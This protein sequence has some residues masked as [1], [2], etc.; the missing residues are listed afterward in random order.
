MAGRKGLGWTFLPEVL[1]FPALSLPGLIALSCCVKWGGARKVF[2]FLNFWQRVTV[3][4]SVLELRYFRAKNV[5]PAYQIKRH[6]PSFHS[7]YMLTTLLHKFFIPKSSSLYLT[8]FTMGK[9]TAV[10]SGPSGSRLLC[11]LFIFWMDN[12]CM[13]REEKET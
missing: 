3:P 8:V 7:F 1:S 2:F 12:L 9:D 5:V 13:E 6:C 11:P 10:L 4:G